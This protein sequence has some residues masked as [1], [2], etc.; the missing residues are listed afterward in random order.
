MKYLNLRTLIVLIAFHTTLFG[1]SK[2]EIFSSEAGAI[3]GYDAVAY[4]NEGKPLKGTTAFVFAWNNA[5]W[6]FTS[7][8][9]LDLF[10][11][12]PEKYAPQYG[13]YC[14]FGM[15]RGYKANTQPDA[16]TIVNNKLYL[17]YNTEVR[18]E[19]NQKQEELINKANKN[20]P[21][22]SKN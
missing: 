19:W 9:N 20:W 22:V 14:A 21:T 1:Q 17:N 8:E 2:S 15:S 5:D 18:T 3:N 6:Y 7:P 4:F 10:K 12:N 11:A 13:G 16:W